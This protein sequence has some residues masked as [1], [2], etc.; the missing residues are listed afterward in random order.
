MAL[1]ENPLLGKQKV[2]HNL[3]FFVV[4]MPTHL[5]RNPEMPPFIG[6]N[7]PMLAVR[8]KGP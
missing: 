3:L 8:T 1:N 4:A 2:L 7:I 6:T 5:G